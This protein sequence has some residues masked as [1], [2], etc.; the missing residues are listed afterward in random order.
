MASF[1]NALAHPRN[2]A[3]KVYVAKVQGLV[4]DEQLE[5]W[6]KSIEIDGRA[7]APAEVRRLR[8]EGDKTW[9]ELTLREGRNRQVRRLGEATGS[10][11]MRLARISHA[12]ITA[13]DLRPGQWRHLSLDELVVLKRDF[14]VPHR[15]RA[16]GTR[17]LGNPGQSQRQ[18]AARGR[19]QA[20]GRRAARSIAA[21]AGHRQGSRPRAKRR[22]ARRARRA[23]EHSA[24]RRAPH[25]AATDPS[26]AIALLARATPRPN[27]APRAPSA[28]ARARAQQQCSSER[29]SDAR[30]SA[31]AMLV[32]AQQRCSSER[33]RC[34]PERSSDARPSASSDAR[35]ERSSSASRAQQRASRAQQQRASGAQQQRAS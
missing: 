14:G 5:E 10:L 20:L 3:K 19:R 26:K 12:G 34:S 35:P 29:S 31:A 27:A 32:R 11:V 1:A 21:R 22:A 6:R 15:V 13:E 25:V 8:F 16:P 30:P 2:K 9:L 4:I 33:E 28:A 18:G 24:S 7:T 23:I 17:G